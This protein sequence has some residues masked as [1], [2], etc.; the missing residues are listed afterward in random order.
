[1]LDDMLCLGKDVPISAW[2][3]LLTLCNQVEQQHFCQR[4]HAQLLKQWADRRVTK[5]GSLSFARRGKNFESVRM[6]MRTEMRQKKG[7]HREGQ[8]DPVSF[9]ARRGCS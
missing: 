5:P 4:N 6:G 1:M 3:F 7:A 2:L 9:E 8:P